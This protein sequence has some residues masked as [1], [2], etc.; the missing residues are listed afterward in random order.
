[1]LRKAWCVFVMQKNARARVEAVAE[2]EVAV[3]GFR[4]HTMMISLVVE[5]VAEVEE[6]AEAQQV[7][8][9]VEEAVVAGLGDIRLFLNLRQAMPILATKK[10]RKA[11]GFQA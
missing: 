11:Q 1:M 5:A 10:K 4:A 8:Q 6:V 3:V 2:E 9:V 7:E